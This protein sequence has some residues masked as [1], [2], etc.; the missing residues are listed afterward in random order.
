MPEK[1]SL[2]KMIDLLQERP[3]RLEDG[4]VCFYAREYIFA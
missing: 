4:D 3:A 1:E 2:W